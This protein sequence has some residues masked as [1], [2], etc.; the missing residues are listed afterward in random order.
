MTATLAD[1]RQL[2]RSFS[3][4]AAFQ[5]HVLATFASVNALSR[6]G[7]SLLWETSGSEVCSVFSVAIP[8]PGNEPEAFNSLPFFLPAAIAALCE[9]KPFPEDATK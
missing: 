1:M 6:K 4:F 3:A 2:T 7:A 9:S 8:P 5:G